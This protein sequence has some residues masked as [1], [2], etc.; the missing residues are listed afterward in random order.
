MNTVIIIGVRLLF[1]GKIYGNNSLFFIN[2]IGRTESDFLLGYLPEGYDSPLQCVT[3]KENCCRQYRIGE[4]YFPNGTQVPKEY[5]ATVIYRNRD[6]SGNVNLNRII[7]T[8]IMPPSGQYCCEVP[9][10]TTMNQ[11]LCAYIGK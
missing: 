3:D 9:D 4:W 8:D 1:K 6:Y 11:T 10:S 7:N 5:H 2:E